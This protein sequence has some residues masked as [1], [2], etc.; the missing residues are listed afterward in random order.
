MKSRNTLT[1]SNVALLKT[2]R[3]IRHQLDVNAQA[4]YLANRVHLHTK[5]NPIDVF[6]DTG[7]KRIISDVRYAIYTLLSDSGATLS[8][9]GRVF[10]RNQTSV[11]RLLQGYTEERLRKAQ[12]RSTPLTTLIELLRY[13][14]EKW[15]EQRTKENLT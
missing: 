13:D 1:Q 8:Q 10:G 7:K 9:I 3:A 6:T 14:S 2:S 4:K 15:I 12:V 5:V 11:S